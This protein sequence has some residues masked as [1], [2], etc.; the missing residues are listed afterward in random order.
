MALKEDIKSSFDISS[1][2]R[3]TVN[4]FAADCAVR[5]RSDLEDFYSIELVPLNRQNPS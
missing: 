2:I 1:Y 4:C 3:T 5:V